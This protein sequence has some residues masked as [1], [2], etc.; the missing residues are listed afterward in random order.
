MGF[1]CKF[2][3]NSRAIFFEKRLHYCT[4]IALQKSCDKPANRRAASDEKPI[5]GVTN[6]NI[7]II[8]FSYN[9]DNELSIFSSKNKFRLHQKPNHDSDID[10]CQLI[11]L[12][13]KRQVLVWQAIG[14]IIAFLAR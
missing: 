2:P 9:E 5:P 3:V 7:Y 13:F 14:V 4:T 10:V 11:D 1:L 12:S 8:I 6:K